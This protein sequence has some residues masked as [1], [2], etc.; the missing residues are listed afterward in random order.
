MDELGR[1]GARRGGSREDQGEEEKGDWGGG[2]DWL[3]GFHLGA[4]FASLV[5]AGRRQKESDTDGQARPLTGGTWPHPSSTL[6]R[7]SVHAK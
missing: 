5:A 2:G 1:S 3:L 4:G 6:G 7:T